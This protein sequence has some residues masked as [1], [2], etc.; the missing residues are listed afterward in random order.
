[1]YVYVFIVACM[2]VCMYVYVLTGM[3]MYVYVFIGVY[4]CVYVCN[5]YM[6]IFSIF[7]CM[8][9]FC[10]RVCVLNV[11][12]AMV[13]VWWTLSGTGCVLPTHQTGVSRTNPIEVRVIFSVCW[14][15]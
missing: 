6:C 11:S 15:S 10:G 4:M 1:M 5:V 7:L 9:F 14:E 12:Q 13:K 2:Y 8:C 3:G